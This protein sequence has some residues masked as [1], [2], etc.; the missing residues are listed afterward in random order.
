MAAI[1]QTNAVSKKRLWTGWIIC[2]I[3]VL[4]L[5]FH[6]VTKLMMIPP[7]IEGTKRLGYPVY[8]FLVI[9]VCTIL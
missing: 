5:V 4:F 9:A 3:S 7:V 2:T 1:N 6:S 8:L